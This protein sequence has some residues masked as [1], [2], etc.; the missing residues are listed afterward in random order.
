MAKQD[1]FSVTFWGVRGSIAC[2]GPETV[3]YGGDTSCL[4][5]VCGDYRMIFDGGTGLRKLGGVLAG[6]GPIDSDI[7]FTHSHFDHVCGLPF[8]APFFIPGNRFRL[9]AGHLLPEHTLKQV[10]VEMM[11]APLFPVPPEIFQ[12]GVS[13]NDY[14]CGDVLTP[15]EGVT[16]RTAPLNHPNRATG[17]RI[18]FDG[19]SICYI[20]DTE[21]FGDGIDQNIAR[22]I[23]GADIVIYDSTYTDEEYPR[24]KGFGHSTW[25]EGVRL[26]EAAQAKTLVIFHHDPSHDDDFMDDIA[27]QAEAERPGTLVAREGMTLRP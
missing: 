1:E 23:A 6:Q 8:F 12:A 19:K 26:V 25:Q 21:H 2:P 16:V 22:L 18:E 4:E 27:K 3:R 15:H 5:V 20:T 17:Y 14:A 13:Y 10:L 7:F 24:F 11:M 9:W